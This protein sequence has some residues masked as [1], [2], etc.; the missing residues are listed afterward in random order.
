MTLQLNILKIVE[1]LVHAESLTDMQQQQMLAAFKQYYKA[2]DITLKKI[3]GD[4]KRPIAFLMHV[5][6]VQS[7]DTVLYDFCEINFDS[8]MLFLPDSSEPA[9]IIKTENSFCL[10]NPVANSRLEEVAKSITVAKKI[11]VK[12]PV[13]ATLNEL[14]E[15]VEFK[16]QSDIP[17]TPESWQIFLHDHTL[18]QQLIETYQS[19]F[20]D[21]TW[22]NIVEKSR[23]SE[24]FLETLA[25]EKG[26]NLVSKYPHL[27]ESFIERHEDKID[28]KS[29]S[30]A[31]P[32]SLDFIEKFKDKLHWETICENQKL[33]E[34]IIDANQD[35]LNTRCWEYIFRKQLLSDEFIQRYSRHLNWNHISLNIHLT[36]QQLVEYEN[37]IAWN[38][39]INYGRKLDYSQISNL[40]EKDLLETG[41]IEDIINEQEKFELSDQNVKELKAVIKKSKTKIKTIAIDDIPPGESLPSSTEHWHTLVKKYQVSEL[42]LEKYYDKI[43]LSLF[44]KITEQIP[45]SSAFL[46][47]HHQA[48]NWDRYSL[49]PHITDHQVGEFKDKWNWN[50]LVAVGRGLNQEL[51]ERYFEKLP[52]ITL[53]QVLTKKY[54]HPITDEFK[55]KIKP[56]I[57]KKKGKK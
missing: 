57:E 16:T 26:W 7:P 3:F 23:L 37:N 49:N 39:L 5:V 17:K 28:W 18:S 54:K 38:L 42:F 34:S 10:V 8:G 51:L 48:I 13:D 27:S 20:E 46:N 30:A 15:I 32:L 33:D 31:S 41:D 25:L 11:K 9:G 53:K 36:D 29:V 1:L 55:E 52:H 19:Y 2:E 35:K 4:D 22:Q 12:P 6:D 21:R 24:G 45:L 14:G 40:I 56:V 44:I 43:P 50:N 47:T